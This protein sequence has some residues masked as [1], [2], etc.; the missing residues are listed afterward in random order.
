MKKKK[1]LFIHPSMYIGGAERSLLSLLGNIDPECYDISLFLYRHVGEFMPYIPSTVHLLPENSCYGTFDVPIRSLLLSSRWK[2]GAARLLGKLLLHKMKRE[3]KENLGVWASMQNISRSLLPLLPVIE[4][5]YDV[6]IQYLGV[7]DVLLEKVNADKKIAWCHTDYTTLGP[8]CKYDLKIY[9]QIDNVVTVSE[10]CRKQLLQIYPSLYSKV[11]V[12]ENMLSPDLITKL[13][14]EP[15]YD[16]K[17]GESQFLLLSVGRYS[18]AKNFDNIPDICRIIRESG[19]N[20]KWYIIGYGGDESLIR[21]KIRESKMEN[22]VILLGKKVNPYPYM[23]ACDLYV[24]PSRYE[25]KCVSVLEAQI[26][27]KPVVIT[28]YATASNQ[29]QNGVDGLIVPMENR[30]C[31]EG[32]AALLRDPERMT[33]FASATEVYDYSNYQELV[34]FYELLE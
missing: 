14:K 33:A 3:T 26:L 6:A 7:P 9:H 10:D 19:L 34:K 18:E 13:S 22:W 25:G 20:V 2:Y 28:N 21:Q 11:K 29:L 32:I 27:H 24:Q 4:G 8:D 17:N 30:E 5:R 1:I 16:L 23:K 12:V 15:A 31:A